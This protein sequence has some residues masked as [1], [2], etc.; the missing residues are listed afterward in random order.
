MEN[1]FQNKYSIDKKYDLPK[2][3]AEE[4]ARTTL[5]HF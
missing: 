2:T 4:Q 1:C 3:E 5:A